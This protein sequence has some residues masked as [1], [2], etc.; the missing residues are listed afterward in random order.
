MLFSLWLFITKPICFFMVFVLLVITF[1]MLD[2]N[3]GFWEFFNAY[4]IF[5]DILELLDVF[6]FNVKAFEEFY[7]ISV[8]HS[9]SLDA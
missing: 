8:S 4:K 6:L 7:V 2:N 1:H 9:G 5:F 3:L